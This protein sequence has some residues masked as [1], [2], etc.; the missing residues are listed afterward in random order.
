M[1]FLAGIDEVGYGPK[2]GPLI[3]TATLF[4]IPE[5]GIDLWR[6]LGIPRDPVRGGIAVCDSKRLYHPPD[7]S[8]LELT[9]LAFWR[10]RESSCETT[11]LEFI[12]GHGL[13]GLDGIREC[14]WYRELAAPLPFTTPDTIPDLRP[15][16]ARAG[17][18][19]AG[20]RSVLADAREF[21]DG[22]ARLRNKAD[23][24][25]EISSRLYRWIWDTTASEGPCTVVVG[26]QGGRTFYADRLQ[27]L[28]PESLVLTS[29]ESP[30][31]STYSIGA[32][33]RRMTMAFAADAEDAHFPVGLASI[34]AKYTREGLMRAFNAW[35]GGRLPG[36]APTAGYAADAKRFL[37][38]TE[39]LRRELGIGDRVLVRER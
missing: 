37:R 21:N 31:L 11:F 14:P 12:E 13:A 3:V 1:P 17:V 20:V 19:F 32:R 38:E 23:F 4:E 2:L 26:K 27:K 9:T 30:A 7:V 25:F 15:A 28:F 18:R 29:G 5:A 16:F 33:D 24:L 22:V 10:A 6:T 39:G 34:V 36:L 8:P 35:W